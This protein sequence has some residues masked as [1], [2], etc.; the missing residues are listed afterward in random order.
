MENI[1][2]LKRLFHCP[3]NIFMKANWEPTFKERHI[4]CIYNIQNKK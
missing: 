4:T 2:L 1:F 3:L